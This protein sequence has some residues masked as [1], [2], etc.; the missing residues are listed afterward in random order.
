VSKS[1]KLPP[2]KPGP[3]RSAIKFTDSEL[4]GALSVSGGNAEKAAA[5]LG[6]HA[7]TVHRRKRLNVSAE[8]ASPTAAV[9]ARRRNA[10]RAP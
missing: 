9:V 6:C 3:T 7:T 4:D 10:R 1:F 5:L 2:W 8:S